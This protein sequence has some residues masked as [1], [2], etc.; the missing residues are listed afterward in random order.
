[1]AGEPGTFALADAGV[2]RQR[3]PLG[4]LRQQHRVGRGDVPR[5]VE[6]EIGKVGRHQRRFG[7]AMTGVL[8]GRAGNVH[9]GRDGIAQ[10]G[11]GEVTGAGHALAQ[12]YVNG[13]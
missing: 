10:P 13:Q 9:G 5:V 6:V 8:A 11:F 4:L 7:Q 12:V 2:H 3:R 1:M